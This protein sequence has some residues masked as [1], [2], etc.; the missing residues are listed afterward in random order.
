MGFE[1]SLGELANMDI[2]KYLEENEY[3]NLFDVI[4]E[5][6]FGHD[7]DYKDGHYRLKVKFMNKSQNPDPEYTS[8]GNSGF[9]LRA[10]LSGDAYPE[11][12]LIIPAGKIALVPT[13]LFFEFPEGFEM[14]IR[15]RSGMAIKFG[16]TVLNTPGTI[17]A[18]YR[19]EVQIIIYNT[20]AVGDFKIANG[21]RIAQAVITAVSSK[22]TINFQKV[23]ALSE[24]DRGEGGFGHSGV[25]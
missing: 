13:G 4:E 25:K 15:P 20:G 10:N 8:T 22:N 5:N 21:D 24:T 19:G 14:Q 12:E 6:N 11:N 7:F 3:K 16:I 18:D 23:S 17:D 1:D 2:K 9:D